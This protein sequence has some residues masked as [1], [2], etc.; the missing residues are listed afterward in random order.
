MPAHVVHLR[1][2]QFEQR[3]VRPPA[4]RG[5][6][7]VHPAPVA[8][9]DVSRAGDRDRDRR[10][11]G[12]RSLGVGRAPFGDARRGYPAEP[13]GETHRD[14]YLLALRDRRPRIRPPRS[15]VSPASR[16]LASS[17]I[18]VL[19]GWPGLSRTIGTPRSTD[20]GTS[21][22]DG[23]SAAIGARTTRSM[24]A[25]LSPTF[26]SARLSTTMRFSRR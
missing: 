17:R 4:Y 16:P 1:P 18:A 2:A 22:L 21:R 20:T 25:P 6:R 13:I 3:L 26:A 5:E 7:V 10:N 19:T 23:T 24:S 15:P 8:P 12:G 14:P 11:R 9:P